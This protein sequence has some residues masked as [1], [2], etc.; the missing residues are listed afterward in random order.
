MPKR[1]STSSPSSRPRCSSR[2]AGQGVR[3]YCADEL[4]G[5]T[6][7]V[8]TASRAVQPRHAHDSLML[9]VVTEGAR[10]IEVGGAVVLV[11]AGS[12]FVLAPGQ[13]HACAP[14]SPDGHSVDRVECCSYLALSVSA[15]ALP[16]ELSELGRWGLASPPTAPSRIDDPALTEA[17]SR[18]AEAMT[19]PAGALERQSLLA[20]CLERLSGL[21]GAGASAGP[22]AMARQGIPGADTLA[23][24]VRMARALIDEGFGEGLDLTGL[25]RTCGVGMFALHRAFTRLVGLPPHAFQTHLRL[26]RAKER[27][28]GGA[29][30]AEA[31]LDAGFC[32]QAHMTRH[33]AR[34]VGLSPAQYAR[35]H[36]PRKG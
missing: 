11:P 20:E 27:L 21:C 22:P 5:V 15:E 9:G 8:A 6:L 25:A 31:A 36:R 18:L 3:L 14:A 29:T 4:P 7:T 26:R 16:S 32:D 30:L 35:A 1:N 24:P 12:A 28:R 34:C 33:F 17:L 13:A 10:R 2:S 23:E 19:R